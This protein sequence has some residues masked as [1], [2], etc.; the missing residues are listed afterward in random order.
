MLVTL[1]LSAAPFTGSTRSYT[2]TANVAPVSNTRAYLHTAS[3]ASK[4]SI[5]K[6]RKP[7]TPSPLK[8]PKPG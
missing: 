4:A 1:T 8:S 3:V 5:N 2:C 7:S 6:Y